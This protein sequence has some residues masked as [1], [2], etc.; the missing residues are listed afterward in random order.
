MIKNRV[1]VCIPVFNGQMTIGQTIESVLGQ[2]YSDFELIIVDNAST[3]DTLRIIKSYKDDRI[4]LVINPITI[5]A[6]ENWTKCVG[7]ARGQW[8]KLLC[9]DDLLMRTALSDSV[10]AMKLHPEVVAVAGSRNVINAQGAEVLASRSLFSIPKLLNHNQVINLSI[11][12]GT[13]PLGESLCIMW[14]SNLTFSAGAFSNIWSYYIDLDYWLRLSCFGD[15]LFIPKKVGSFR[16]S[17]T[18]WTSGMGLAAIF[19]AKK[20]YIKYDF[21]SNINPLRR[22]MAFVKAMLKVFAR[23]I[24]I[25]IRGH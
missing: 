9:A 4:D 23:K 21:F 12:T 1:S 14:R 24:F 15:F 22:Y 7:L 2:D 18:S 6:N 13:N 11:S 17:P 5:P 20:F 3:D 10:H 25:V 8:T 16:I 19:E